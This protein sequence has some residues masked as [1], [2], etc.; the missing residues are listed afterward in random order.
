MTIKRTPRLLLRGF[1]VGE[2][3]KVNTLTLK[4]FS[5]NAQDVST[6]TTSK[7]VICRSPD[8]RKTITATGAYTTNGADGKVYWTFSSSDP[9]DRAGTWTGQ[10]L[11]TKSGGKLH[12]YPFDMEVELEI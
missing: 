9:L 3:G 6:Y 1:V 7:Q 2:Y 8:G 4:D 5:G 12:T 11:L 10:V